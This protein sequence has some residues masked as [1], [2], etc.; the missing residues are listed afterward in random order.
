MSDKLI[1]E[2][3]KTLAAAAAADPQAVG[4]A[5]RDRLG[6]D[7]CKTGNPI[8]TGIKGVKKARR[9]KK[10]IAEDLNKVKTASASKKLTTVMKG[11]NAKEK[12]TLS[13]TGVK[14]M[15]KGSGKAKSKPLIESK[16]VE[17]VPEG[18][19]IPL[20]EPGS[21][22]D[23][24]ED[25]SLSLQTLNKTLHAGLMADL[26]KDM[27]SWSTK[28]VT[29]VETSDILDISLTNEEDMINDF[30]NQDV[31]MGVLD[32]EPDHTNS[33]VPDDQL[34]NQG[35]SAPATTSSSTK[36]QANTA[37]APSQSST[38][39]S[40]SNIC[41]ECL[42]LQ[43]TIRRLEDDL[44]YSYERKNETMSDLNKLR[45]ESQQALISANNYREFARNKMND[46]AN[47]NEVL[48][49]Q[50]NKLVKKNSDL[51]T[52][53]HDLGQR[54]ISSNKAG[55]ASGTVKLLTDE[56]ERYDLVGTNETFI[57]SPFSA[58]E[59]RHNKKRN[60]DTVVEQTHEDL[61][62]G[63]VRHMVNSE[64]GK[65]KALKNAKKNEKVS[66]VPV[67]TLMTA[68]DR[69]SQSMM[70]ISD[71]SDSE[72]SLEPYTEEED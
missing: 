40:V 57:Q 39:A 15:K 71:T 35:P 36:T 70:E 10:Q 58:P 52:K 61:T 22:P 9:T 64:V 62:F 46:L 33:H 1:N 3:Y 50:V 13:P 65:Q 12:L 47:D 25:P 4:D 60:A 41:V 31:E 55:K 59:V 43:K 28:I 53:N 67:K 21:V 16:V 68:G 8:E 45:S 20:K 23:L 24:K 7:A 44:Q 48:K 34:N 63:D 27:Q 17:V 14:T 66:K 54:L 72:G 56:T 2:K 38:T 37:E 29:K 18:T 19:Q 42:S 26:E 51:S 32:D 5:V 30:E 11:K 6:H 69:I 49:E